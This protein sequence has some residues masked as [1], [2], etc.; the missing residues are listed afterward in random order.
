MILKAAVL[1]LTLGTTAALAYS[2][3]GWDKEGMDIV[4][5]AVSVVSGNNL[6]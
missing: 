3:H 1:P 6:I 4:V 5:T 2:G